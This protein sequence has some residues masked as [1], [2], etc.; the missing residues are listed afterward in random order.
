MSH[1]VRLRH[2]WAIV[3]RASIRFCMNI[4]PSRRFV[5]VGSHIIWQSLKKGSCRLGRRNDEKIQSWR[6][7][8]C[9][10][11]LHRILD[12]CVWARNKTAIYCLGL[13]RRAKSNESCSCTKHFEAH[14]GLFLRYKWS[15]RN[16]AFSET[17]YGRFWM[18]H[19]HLFAS[20]VPEREE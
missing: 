15:C 2:L 11:H 7:K 6:I 14:G 18:V 4:W 20:S 19:H 9:V 3:W 5:R 16:S 1:I 13:P 8:V 10:Q 17:L 12:L